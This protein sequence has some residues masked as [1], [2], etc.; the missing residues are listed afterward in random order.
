MSQIEILAAI[1][2]LISVWLTVTENIWCWP[3]G[4]VMVFLYIFIFYEARLY[5]DAILQVIYVFLQIYGWYAWLHGGK[6]RGELH[7]TRITRLG[8]IVWGGVAIAASFTLGFVMHRYTDA[9]LP[10][11]DAAITVISLVAQWL[12]AKKVLECWLLWI[13][14]DVLA[15]G[16]YAVKKLYPTTGLYV[17]FLVLAVLGYLTWNKALKKRLL[18]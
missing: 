8:A 6:D 3:T 13:T 1:F 18:V 12:M 2:G 17:V 16:V 7:V 4:L 10:Y 11:W 5:S 9:A 14:V 15:V